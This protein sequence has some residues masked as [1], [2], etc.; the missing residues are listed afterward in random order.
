MFDLT[1]KVCVVSGGSRGIGLGMAE[2]LLMQGAAVQ[3]WGTSAERNA[4]AC[5]HLEAFG[6]HVS[7]QVI[8][9]TDEAQVVAGMQAAQ[10]AFGRIDTV[11]ANAGGSFRSPSFVETNSED[12]HQTIALN[13]DGAFWTLREATRHMVE[14]AKA[15]DLGGSLIGTASMGA[16]FGTPRVQAY[17]AAKAGLISMLKGIAVEYARYGIRANAILPGWIAT[18]LTDQHQSN[19]K[20]NDQVIGRVPMRRW[21][22]PADFRGVA[23]YLASDASSFHTADALLLDGG[24]TAY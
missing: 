3:I 14:R 17:G 24:Y 20:F 15:G 2:G 21:G 12:W 7:S 5:R 8:D 22:G 9:V 1:G 11:I 16:L 19:E 23:V 6:A 18:D 13:L 10:S 4:D